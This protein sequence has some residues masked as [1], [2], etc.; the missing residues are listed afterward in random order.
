MS[1]K[2][3]EEK[4][5]KNNKIIKEKNKLV[6]KKIPKSKIIK[7]LGIDLSIGKVK[8]CLL[9]YDSSTK[10]IGGGWSSLPVNFEYISEKQ[11][12]YSNGPKH[13]Y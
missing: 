11:Y 4:A 1:T 6:D 8:L 5:S 3:N 2:K 7:T 13:S 9:T 10:N 12:E